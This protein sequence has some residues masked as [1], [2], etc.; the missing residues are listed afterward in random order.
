[1]SFNFQEGEILLIDKPLLWTSFDVVGRLRVLMQKKYGQKFKVGH[2]GTLD[3]MAT[4][5]LIICTGK[6]TKEIEK[7]QGCDKEYIATLELGKT[8][9]SFDRE[10]EVDHIYPINHITTALIEESL[11]NFIG[12]IDQIPPLFSAKFINGKRAYEYARKGHVIEM[13]PNKVSIKSIEILEFSSPNLKLKIVCSK[14]TYIRSLARDIGASLGSGAY[15][16]GLR[17]TASGEFKIDEAD[18][19]ESFSEKLNSL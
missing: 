10:T 15:L 1:M 8:T 14:G 11:K 9:P 6:K 19:I 13:E 18:T 5:L 2:A 17:R 4:G 3:P 16:I 7:L 12:T